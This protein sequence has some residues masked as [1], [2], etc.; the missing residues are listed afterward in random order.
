MCSCFP[1]IHN[2]EVAAPKYCSQTIRSTLFL[3]LWDHQVLVYQNR[4]HFLW[5]IHEMILNPEA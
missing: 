2:I 3:W 4:N 1:I 5:I